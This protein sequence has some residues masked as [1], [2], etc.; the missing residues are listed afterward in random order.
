MSIIALGEICLMT[1]MRHG[2]DGQSFICIFIYLAN[3]Y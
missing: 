2:K 1:T 3:G